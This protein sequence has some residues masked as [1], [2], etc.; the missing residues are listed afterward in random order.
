MPWLIRVVSAVASIVLED[1]NDLVA[2]IGLFV[3]C[4]SGNQLGQ[5][6]VA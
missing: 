4:A 3:G 6:D 1:L 2:Y 5:A